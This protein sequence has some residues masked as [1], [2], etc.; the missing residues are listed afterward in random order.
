MRRPRVQRH[1]PPV[2]LVRM[3]SARDEGRGQA[4][5]PSA[6]PPTQQPSHDH[7]HR[8]SCQPCDI[9][10]HGHFGQTHHSPPRPPQTRTTPLVLPLT[11]HL[12]ARQHQIG[13]PMR[14]DRERAY[15]ESVL[16]RP[17]P[18]DT[19]IA[20]DRDGSLRFGLRQRVDIGVSRTL[21]RRIAPRPL[22]CLANRQ[23][24]H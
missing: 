16:K 3:T 21:M 1:L 18:R 15:F 2:L 23:T 11:P 14:A 20:D 8:P 22:T 10:G 24:W 6:R 13:I 12:K 4:Q 5:S 7:R 19:V 17:R 9:C